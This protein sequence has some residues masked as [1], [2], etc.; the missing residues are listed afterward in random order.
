MN[1]SPLPNCAK[2]IVAAFTADAGLG[3]LIGD[4]VYARKPPGGAVGINPAVLPCVVF[5]VYSS[6]GDTAFSDDGDNRVAV[7]P[8]YTIKAVTQADDAASGYA[9]VQEF[10]RIMRTLS[11]AVAWNGATLNIQGWRNTQGWF[12]YSEEDAS[13]LDYIHTGSIYRA[14]VSGV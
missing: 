4:R 10:D 12:E 5:S 6:T 1:A 14:F 2:M 7:Y 3:A 13:G 8:Y 9:I 11:G